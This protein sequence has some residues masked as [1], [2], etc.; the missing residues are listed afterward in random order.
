[1]KPMKADFQVDGERLPG[2]VLN[3]G[4]AGMFIGTSNPP[5]P[6]AEVSVV[7]E[8][9]GGTKVEARGTV[10]WSTAD[11][12]G[13]VAGFGMAIDS[14]SRSYLELYEEMLRAIDG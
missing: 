4:G 7:I 13:P 10:R 11:E 1:M 8:D 14:P 9:A 12:K 3:L 2:R 5:G 6:G